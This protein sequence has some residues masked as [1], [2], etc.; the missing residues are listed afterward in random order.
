VLYLPSDIIQY[1]LTATHSVLGGMLSTVHR[2]ANKTKPLPL[3]STYALMA[4]MVPVASPLP[5][6]YKSVE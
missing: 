6:N 2:K 1:V 4:E 3:K 5:F